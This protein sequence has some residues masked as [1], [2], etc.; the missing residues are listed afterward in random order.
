MLSSRN[1]LPSG[2][3]LKA[4]RVYPRRWH[5]RRRNPLPS[6][7][8]LKAR[9]ISS[10]RGSVT[11]QSS[12]LWIRSE[13]HNFELVHVPLRGRNPLPSGY[14]L[15]A[16]M[17]VP[18]E[19]TKL[20]RNPLPSGYGL[21]ATGRFGHHSIQMGSQSSSLWIR[22]ESWA[23]KLYTSSETSRNPL[24]SGYGLK[25]ETF[26]WAEYK[27]IVAILFPLDTV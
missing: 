8:G 20:C 27:Y 9:C 7:Y 21:K 19:F 1:P 26:L 4:H 16:I 18:A 25:A 23:T 10:K 24:P 14:G 11:S 6:G 12:S 3:G 5:V 22:S 17:Y 13:S 2:Y 15:K